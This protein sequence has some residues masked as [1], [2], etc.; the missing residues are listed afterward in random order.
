MIGDNAV[1]TGKTAARNSVGNKP[2]SYPGSVGSFVI[3]LAEYYVASTGYTAVRAQAEAERFKP[4][5]VIFDGTTRPS[6]LGGSAIKIKLVF[7]G[8]NQQLIGAQLLSS[9]NIAAHL[10]RLSLAI[11]QRLTAAEISLAE[12]CYTPATSWT[13]GPVAQAVDKYLVTH[14]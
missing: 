7:N 6:Y 9:E 4:E 14:Q 10:D 1:R 3:R 2:L 11:M 13:Y 8:H 12:T 5:I